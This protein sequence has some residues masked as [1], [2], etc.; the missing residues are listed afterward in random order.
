[1]NNV[2]VNSQIIS[3]FVNVKINEDNLPRYYPLRYTS[4]RTMFE[5]IDLTEYALAMLQGEISQNLLQDLQSL[6]TYL[7]GKLG[8]SQA[9]TTN[10]PKAIKLINY[11]QEKYS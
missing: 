8:K 2:Q 10:D 7:I 5:E 6:N 4:S 9:S 11:L 1:M 3:I